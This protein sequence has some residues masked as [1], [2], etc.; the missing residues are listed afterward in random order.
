[1][2]RKSLKINIVSYNREKT[3]QTKNQKPKNQTCHY[4][5]LPVCKDELCP[6]KTPAIILETHIPG[7]DFLVIVV[8][9]ELKLTFMLV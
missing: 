9:R 2:L 1:M 5:P 6:H 4:C 8:G 7:S 3:K